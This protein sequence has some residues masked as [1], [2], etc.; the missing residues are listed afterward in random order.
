MHI[1][2]QIEQLKNKLQE[3]QTELRRLQAIR[4]QSLELERIAHIDAVNKLR[5]IYSSAKRCENCRDFILEIIE[6]PQLIDWFD[7]S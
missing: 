7:K 6:D 2:T 1:D 5:E 3:T 4:A